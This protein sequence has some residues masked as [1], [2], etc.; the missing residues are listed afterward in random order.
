VH[1]EEKDSNWV[2]GEQT[3][4]RVGSGGERLFGGTKQASGDWNALMFATFI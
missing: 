3:D 2:D 4:A 1:G